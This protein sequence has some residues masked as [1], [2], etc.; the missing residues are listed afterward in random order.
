MFQAWR[1][2]EE[3]QWQPCTWQQLD[4]ELAA[5]ARHKRPTQAWQVLL[6][7]PVSDLQ[8]LWQLRLKVSPLN[9]TQLACGALVRIVWFSAVELAQEGHCR[10]LKC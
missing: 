1:E 8:Q 10:G 2:V 9:L 3:Q 6:R 4:M 7:A 5:A